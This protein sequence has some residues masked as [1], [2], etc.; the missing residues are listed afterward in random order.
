MTEI[1][2]IIAALLVLS[3][4]VGTVRG[5]VR[6]TLAV[7]GWVVGIMAA[8][9]FSGELA[10]LIPLETI[11]VIPRVIIASVIIVA[12]VLFG[13]GLLGMLLRK[14]LEAAEISFEDRVLGA[15][16]GL[17]R[18]IVVVCGCVFLAGMLDSVQSSKMWRQSALIAPAEILIEWSLPYLP[19]AIADMR[20]GAKPGPI[21]DAARTM[22]DKIA[23]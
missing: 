12:A 20:A 5:V 11:G 21:E 22:L 13:I 15:V 17:A 1:D 8:L 6:E 14:L 19:S 2:W 4:L 18:G 10:D 7:A 23:L 16:F 3:T 9:S